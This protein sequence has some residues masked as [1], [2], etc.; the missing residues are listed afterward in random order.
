MVTLLTKEELIQK[1]NNLSANQIKHVEEKM[2]IAVMVV[3]AEAKKNATPGHSPY[4]DMFFPTKWAFAEAHGLGYSGAPYMDD[5]NPAREPPHMR[6]TMYGVVET[7]G[8][9]VHGIVGTPKEYA[10]RV[11][12]GTSKMWGRPFLTD[13]GAAKMPKVIEILSEAVIENLQ[14]QSE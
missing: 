5:Q 13:A 3:E 7:E 9:S 6:D 8:L 11:H 4:E 14:E 1:L 10:L 12:E 2:R